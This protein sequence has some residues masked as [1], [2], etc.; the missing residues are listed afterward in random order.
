MTPANNDGPAIN[1]IR[2]PESGYSIPAPQLGRGDYLMLPGMTYTW[3]VRASA[4]A[5][6]A[7]E[8]DPSWGPWTV[9]TFRTP[10]PNAASL[11]LVN[12][13]D[14]P[15]TGMESVTLQWRDASAALFYY[16]VQLS[17]DPQFRADPA[18][19][20][21]PVYWN[22]VHGGV[23]APLNS[24]ASPSLT[25]GATYY[26][27]VRPRVQGDGAQVPWSASRR[28]V[29]APVASAVNAISPITFGAALANPLGCA[30]S[31]PLAA[32]PAGA[33]QAA[34]RFDAAG[35]GGVTVRW[36]LKGVL[37]QVD[38]RSVPSP[39]GCLTAALAS[40][41]GLPAGQ[42]Q[43]EVLAAGKLLGSATFTVG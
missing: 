9:R 43:V 12:P 14:G 27:R 17:P 25:P 36:S 41:G 37:L 19:A 29:T 22:I 1:L 10:A 4:K 35:Q 16:E 21:A 38:D 20:V 34:V 39:G 26:W 24:W 5:G 8:G 23:T 40:P 32:F 3:R 6:F 33:P 11:T 31:G 18:T 15:E 7:A 28:F 2:S 13:P 42:Y 30:L